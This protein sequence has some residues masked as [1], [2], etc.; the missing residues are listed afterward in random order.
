[1][2]RSTLFVALTLAA[3]MLLSSTSAFAITAP[4]TWTAL[5][6]TG[7]PITDVQV[8]K[9]ESSYDIKM[10]LTG[11]AVA[12]NTYSVYLSPTAAVFDEYLQDVSATASTK[13]RSLSVTFGL[14]DWTATT[15]GWE[16]TPGTLI[17]SNLSTDK[18]TLSWLVAQS[19]VLFQT[20]W[21]AGQVTNSG[22]GADLGKTAVSATP[23]PGA[24]W[25]LGSGILGLVALR[26]KKAGMA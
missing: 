4:T 21:F 22:S 3:S 10:N 26:R 14:T 8:T 6:E 17:S 11:P 13:L 12:G 20:F 2:K 15:D 18:K 16:Q 9:D 24:A 7:S 1:M 25:L 19:D 5:G 23:I